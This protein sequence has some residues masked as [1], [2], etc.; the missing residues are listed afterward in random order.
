MVYIKRKCH[1]FPNP[2]RKRSALILMNY[3]D[4]LF[5]AN[6]DVEVL[7]HLELKTRSRILMP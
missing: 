7:Y 5:Y 1:I 4:D 3:L 6:S 2:I